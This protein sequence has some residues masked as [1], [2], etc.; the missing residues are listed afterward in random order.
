MKRKG[1]KESCRKG[2]ILQAAVLICILFTMCAFRASARNGLVSGKERE[3][4]LYP[5][6]AEALETAEILPT[7]C[8]PV[9]ECYR[10]E[11]GERGFSEEMLADLQ[12]EGGLADTGLSG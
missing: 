3:N 12:Q 8:T 1:E 11:G 5:S 6:E 2:H 4:R 7:V 9:S 10:K